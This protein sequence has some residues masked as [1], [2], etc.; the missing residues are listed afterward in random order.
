MSELINLVKNYIPVSAGLREGLLHNFKP[1]A[2]NKK[3]FFIK[4]GQRNVSLAFIQ[5]GILRCYNLKEDRE[6]T[7]D[8]FFEDIFVTDFGSFLNDQPARQNFEAIE[9]TKLLVMSRDK[10]FS[11]TE[12]FPELRQWGAKVAENLFTQSLA[13]QAV[14]KAD[15]PE[16]RYNSLLEKRPGIIN[17]IPLHYIASYLGI[18]QVHLSR[19]RSKR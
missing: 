3:E 9:S 14:L 4:E 7:N 18:T 8:F 16:E 11:L 10:L 5:S 19:I 2:L 13:D 12:N 15:S 1:I 17:R 6:V